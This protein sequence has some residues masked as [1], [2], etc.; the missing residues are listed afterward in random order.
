MGRVGR[1]RRSV[2]LFSRGYVS[3]PLDT[4]TSRVDRATP[5]DCCAAV[6]STARDEPIEPED[7]EVNEVAQGRDEALDEG[8]WRPIRARP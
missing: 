6:S 5:Q 4:D 7:V 8:A 3:F 2:S 1:W